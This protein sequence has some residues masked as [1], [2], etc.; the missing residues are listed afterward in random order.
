MAYGLKWFR[1]WKNPQ[2]S[3]WD[4]FCRTLKFPLSPQR[5]K[6][7]SLNVAGRQAAGLDEE[8]IAQLNV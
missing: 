3:D 6:G 8:F 2:E 5:A 7:F 4:A 1:R